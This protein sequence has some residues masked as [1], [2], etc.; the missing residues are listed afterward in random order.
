MRGREAQGTS[1][2]GNDHSNEMGTGSDESR[3][4]NGRSAQPTHLVLA[5]GP[6]ALAQDVLRAR[7]SCTLP[8]ALRRCEHLNGACGKGY[9][10]PTARTRCQ[11]LESLKID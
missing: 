6:G 3:D 10:V 1:R 7:H 5:A 9:L 4:E 8:G 11:K 2:D